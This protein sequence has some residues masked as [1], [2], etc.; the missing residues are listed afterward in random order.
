[1]IT[2]KTM[3]VRG[4][5]VYQSLTVE[6]NELLQV[7]EQLLDLLC[8]NHGLSRHG[9]LVHLSQKKW[10]REREMIREYHSRR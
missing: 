2:T 10:N 7:G 9:Y 5:R 4:T 6:L 1:M 3:T 8:R